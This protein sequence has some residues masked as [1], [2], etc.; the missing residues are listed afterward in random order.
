MLAC[1]NE[2]YILG[3]RLMNCLMTLRQC[4]RTVM[5]LFLT[6]ALLV[7]LKD[8]L[9]FARL[10]SIPRP[11]VSVLVKENWVNL[12]LP[13]LCL[14][15]LTMYNIRRAAVSPTTAVYRDWPELLTTIRSC[16]NVL[17]LVRGLLC[18]PIT[19]CECAAV[20][21]IV[22]LRKLVCRATRKFRLFTC[23]VLANS[24][25][26]TRNGSSLRLTAPNGMNCCIRQPL[27]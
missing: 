17:G 18:A 21:E 11:V 3:R 24:R 8:V 1:G 15:R 19:G 22:L 14:V 5:V 2:E 20:D 7:T 23:F 16:S 27:R 10:W 9:M 12:E 13:F 6:I 26:A 4:L 25:W